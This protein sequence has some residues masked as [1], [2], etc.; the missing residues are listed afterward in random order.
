MRE[1]KYAVFL[2]NAH[3]ALNLSA[4]KVHT[5]SGVSTN[6]VARYA[7]ANGVLIDQLNTSLIA[8][9]RFYKVPFHQAVR[10]VEVENGEIVRFLDEQD[11]DVQQ[12]ISA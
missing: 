10:P 12:P 8:L 6:T 9:A 4:Y 7:E 11:E 2:K 5:L 1:F 3:D